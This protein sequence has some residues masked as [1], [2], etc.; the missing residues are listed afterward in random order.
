[1]TCCKVVIAVALIIYTTVHAGN[2]KKC[3]DY[4]KCTKKCRNDAKIIASDQDCSATTFSDGN[5]SL[6]TTSTLTTAVT[7]HSSVQSYRTSCDTKGLDGVPLGLAIGLLFVGMVIGAVITCL[8]C[9]CVP[10]LNRKATSVLS[11][12]KPK[13]DMMIASV[14]Q[15]SS[16][17]EHKSTLSLYRDSHIYTGIQTEIPLLEGRQIASPLYY[18]ISEDGVPAPA[19]EGPNTD[20]QALKESSS[21][22]PYRHID[23]PGDSMNNSIGPKEL[24][25]EGDEAT[26]HNYFKLSPQKMFSEDT[27][28]MAEK[29]DSTAYFVLVKDPSVDEEPICESQHNYFIL[30]NENDF[31]VK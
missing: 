17:L 14:P 19:T 12:Q 22:D 11:T 30:E 8:L 20:Y 4:E 16:Q 6:R 21:D 26:N 15:T 31:K 10:T 9:V 7:A 25:D 23:V 13:K 3:D 5:D 29:T 28:A 27:S 1:M 18:V 24:E 2:S